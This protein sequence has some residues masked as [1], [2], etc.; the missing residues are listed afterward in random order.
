[1]V[2]QV[3]REYEGRVLF[4]TSPGQDG[5]PAMERAVSDFKWPD[6]MVHAVDDGGKLWRH[7]DVVYRGAWIFVNED[8]TVLEQSLTHIPG[9]E[10]R[11]NLDR[12]VDS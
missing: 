9:D 2:A 1:M 3:A 7:F 12:L 4:V 10:V 11:A 6:S 8:G 5:Q